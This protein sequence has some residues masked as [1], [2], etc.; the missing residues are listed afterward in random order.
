MDNHDLWVKFSQSTFKSNQTFMLVLSLNLQRVN[1]KYRIFL[2]QIHSYSI[3]SLTFV[4]MQCMPKDP[5][6]VLVTS[7]DSRVRVYDG[8]DLV[9]KYKGT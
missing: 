1:L 3:C 9:A 6:K 7:N 8:L 2:V 4:C 5:N